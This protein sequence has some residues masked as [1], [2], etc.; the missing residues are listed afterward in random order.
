MAEDFWTET[1][2]AELRYRWER[3][4]VASDIGNALGTTKG[5]ILGKARR[6]LLPSRKYRKKPRTGI[7]AKINPQRTKP[8]PKPERLERSYMQERNGYRAKPRPMTGAVHF[9][10]C[11]YIE[12]NPTPDDPCGHN[13]SCKCGA[14]VIEGH[15]Y[16]EDHHALCYV[17][18]VRERAEPMEDPLWYAQ[19]VQRQ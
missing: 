8:K 3:G 5:A 11:Q 4:E 12:G 10:T 14:L 2:L 9:L 15:S 19:R 17:A 16:C 6:L 1:R 13:D 7:R 18:P